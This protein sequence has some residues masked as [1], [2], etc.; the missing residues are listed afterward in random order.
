MKDY[1]RFG[2]PE[3]YDDSYEFWAV[4]REFEE[5]HEVFVPDIND[6]IGA[7][8]TYEEAYSNSKFKLL[9]LLDRIK[10]IGEPI[11]KPSSMD[12]IREIAKRRVDEQIRDFPTKSWNT[13]KV[14]VDI[15][16]PV[17][18]LPEQELTEIKKLVMSIAKS[19]DDDKKRI[20][21]TFS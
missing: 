6:A 5:F 10:L 12:N 8:D 14:T 7:G 15:R 1:I 19:I 9:C 2:M 20:I 17:P 3:V 18:I 21:C 4:H 11:P 13:V 16:N